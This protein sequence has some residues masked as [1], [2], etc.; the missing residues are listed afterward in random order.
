MDEVARTSRWYPRR[1]SSAGTRAI[2][3]TR[4][5]RARWLEEDSFRRVP[6]HTRNGPKRPLARTRLP[7]SQPLFQFSLR[8]TSREM[9]TCELQFFGQKG[10]DYATSSG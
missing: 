1:T 9:A 8:A 7:L 10:G 4:D 5:N 3:C 6:G 2:C